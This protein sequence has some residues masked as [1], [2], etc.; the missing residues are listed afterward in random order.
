MT[1]SATVGRTTSTIA[2]MS[3]RGVKYWPA[4]D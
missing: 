4:D 1:R 3:A 2:W